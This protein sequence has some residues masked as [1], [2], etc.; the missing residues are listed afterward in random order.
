MNLMDLLRKR[1]TEADKRLTEQRHR[2]DAPF[3]HRHPFGCCEII[4]IHWGL[5]LQTEFPELSIRIAQAYNRDNNEWHYWLE[6]ENIALDLTAHQFEQYDAPLVDK[7]PSPLEGRFSDIKR[8]TLC[9]AEG[10]ANFPINQQ[11]IE[12][13]R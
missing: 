1:A 3:L 11:L 5:T 8:L 4:S 9:E 10:T 6:L 12:L 13:L 7:I 2:I